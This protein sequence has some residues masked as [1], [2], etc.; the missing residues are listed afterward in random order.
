MTFRPDAITTFVFRG[1]DY[2]HARREVDLHYAFEPGGV[3]FTE[4]ITF[5]DAEGPAPGRHAFALLHLLAGISYYKAACPPEI[6]VE[7]EIAPQV[8][9]FCETVYRNGLG[10]FAYA[11]G[12]T[13]HD[14][15][16]FPGHADPGWRDEA[17]DPLPAAT[18]VPIGGGKDSLVTASL[19]HEHG[20]DF[21]QISIGS[22]PLIRQVAEQVGKPHIRIR[23]RLS[24]RL[25]EL[26]RRGAYNGHVPI[27]AIL[28]AVM[29]CGARLYGYDTVVMSNERSAEQANV[30][31]ADGFMVNHQYSKTLAFE[32]DFDRVM[33]DELG[34]GFRYFSLLRP[35]S[36]L[37]IA[38]YF[39][40]LSKYHDVFSSCNRNF[41]LQGD[42]P[43]DRWCR[44]CPKCRFVFLALA[45]FMPPEPLTSMFGG[46]LLDD[47]SQL[48][49]YRALLGL[50]A[51]KPFE[52]VGEV[53]ES[54]AA[55]T[56]VA[57]QPGWAPCRV[58]AVLAQAFDPVPLGPWLEPAAD[59]AIPEDFQD[60][61]HA[62]GRA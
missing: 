31:L 62:L 7:Y 59:H 17:R 12:L 44:E 14:R 34:G 40:R 32:R 38:R 47:E 50:D 33:H 16:H 18:V 37:A 56:A 57:N 23:R 48:D 41:R 27:S 46:N 9:R 45:P 49:G 21:R 52:C 5:A 2:D 30:M 58:V 4:T 55:M 11:N 20:R 3:H 24:D 53:E 25:L 10:E 15:I 1:W 39:S 35:W 8:A 19:L 54:R 13:L 43:A 28:A 6:R 26:N 60:I 29:R 61:S 51:L 36:E 22:S 42:Q